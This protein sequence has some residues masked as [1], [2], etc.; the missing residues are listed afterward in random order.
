MTPRIK[1]FDVGCTN[2]YEIQVYF[3]EI[4]RVMAWLH[5]HALMGAYIAIFTLTGRN[6]NDININLQIMNMAIVQYQYYPPEGSEHY[7]DQYNVRTHR[8][9]FMIEVKLEQYCFGLDACVRSMIL[10][11]NMPAYDLLFSSKGY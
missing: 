2:R 10:T 6:K 7:L 9:S 11:H 1:N 8:R 5:E 3:V 4:K